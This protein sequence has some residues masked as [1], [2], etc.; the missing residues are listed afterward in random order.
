[1]TKSEIEDAVMTCP[2]GRTPG[3]DGLPYEFYKST[4]EV[5]SDEFVEVVKDQLRNFVLIP[6]GRCGVTVLQGAGIP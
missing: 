1:M 4:W 2:N 5:I 3:I 6:S